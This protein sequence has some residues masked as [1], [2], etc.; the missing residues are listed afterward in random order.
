MDITSG[1]S[2]IQTGLAINAFRHMGFKISA[3]ICE[4]IDNAIEAEATEININ[5]EFD[6]KSIQKHQRISKI[7]F[8][9]NGIGMDTDILQ[10]CLVLGEGTKRGLKNSIGKFGVGATFG[11]ISQG[12]YIG[13]FSKTKTSE[14]QFTQLDLNLLEQGHGIPKP[15]KKEPPI[16]FLENIKNSGT[17][18][19]WDN[20][21]S[22]ASEKDLNEAIENIG[23]IYRKFISHKII[24]DGEIVDIDPIEIKVNGV[25]IEPY[26]PLYVTHSPDSKDKE[27]AEIASS[28]IFDFLPDQG[29]M[30]ITISHLPKSWY[31]DPKMYKP[32]SD[33]SNK[34]RRKMSSANMGISIVRA[35]RE[36]AFGEIAHLKLLTEKSKEDG[37]SYFEPE[38]RFTGIEISFDRDSDELF[39]IEANKSKMYLPRK[40]R[41]KIGKIL[42]PILKT[43][44]EDFTKVRGKEKKPEGD[45]NKPGGKSKITIQNNMPSPHYT[46]QEKEKIRKFA[47][48]LGSNKVE[49]D[50]FY[51]DLVSGYLP[52]HSWDLDPEG[53]FV[54]YE[55]KLKSIVVKY[56]MN[57]PFMKKFFETLEDI[58]LRKGVKKEEALTVE[59]IQRTKTLFDLLLASYGLAEISFQNPNHSEE[60]GNTLSTIKRTWG[61]ISSRITGKDIKSE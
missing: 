45:P 32:G 26:D 11:G 53:P 54:Q 23:R 10:N 44:R 29:E 18:V 52:M 5:I 3:A 60:I 51:N 22:D 24:K 33:P 13:L 31:K 41:E 20:I 9:D 37:G 42:Y 19:I 46:E 15:I 57:H 58:A 47:E 21:D 16:E 12:K 50:E 43:R 36:M 49:I 34:V 14:W 39:G 4:L 6:K 27:L 1:I 56:N 17:V 28:E 61:D 2:P 55:N 40:T 38:D 35:G 30:R 25:P 59:E 7:I 48:Q 8:V